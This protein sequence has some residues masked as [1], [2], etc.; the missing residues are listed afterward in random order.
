MYELS[1]TGPLIRLTR[2]VAANLEIFSGQRSRLLGIAYR[3]LGSRADAEDVVQDTW[4]RWHERDSQR[5]RSTEAWLTTT[6]TRL[7][8]DRLRSAKAQRAVYFEPW[9]PEPLPEVEPMT[10][11]SHAE[12]RTIFRSRFSRC[13][14]D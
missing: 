13:S 6:V 7:S 12:S 11:E 1:H 2:V 4:L 8:I 9:L 5:L 3:M 14:S 10:P